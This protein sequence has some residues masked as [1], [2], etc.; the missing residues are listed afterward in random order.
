MAQYVMKLFEDP[1]HEQFRVLDRDGEPWFVLKEVCAKLEIGN[2]SDVAARLDEDE[3]DDIDLID[4]IGRNQKTRVINE[5]GLYSVILRSNKPQAKVFKKWI[6]SE[7]VS[8]THLRA[9]ET[10]G[11]LVCRL[12]LEKKK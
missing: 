11:N 10:R 5:S 8:Y 9:H 12:L 3:K 6:T 7:A 1:Q 4:T 2:P